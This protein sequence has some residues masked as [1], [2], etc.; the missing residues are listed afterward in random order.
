MMEHDITSNLRLT[1]CADLSD[2]L[3]E[4]HAVPGNHDHVFPYDN[5]LVV[6]CEDINSRLTQMLKSI[7][8]TV[9]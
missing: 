3:H 6:A 4:S 7:I 5:Y 9:Q 2:T 1:L 8:F